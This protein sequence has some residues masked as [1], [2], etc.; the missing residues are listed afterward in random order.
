[1]V[2][3]FVHNYYFQKLRAVIK[4]TEGMRVQLVNCEKREEVVVN[5]YDKQWQEDLG[6]EIAQSDERKGPPSQGQGVISSMSKVIFVKGVGLPQSE[7]QSD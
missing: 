7:G 4:N 2:N 3:V 5:P 1:M 6:K